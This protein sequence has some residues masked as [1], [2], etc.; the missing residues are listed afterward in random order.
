MVQMESG[1]SRYAMHSRGRS[2]LSEIIIDFYQHDECNIIVILIFII[3]YSLNLSFI[4]NKFLSTSSNKDPMK[5][6]S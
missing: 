1:E 6:L 4:S 5:L 2:V 3:Y